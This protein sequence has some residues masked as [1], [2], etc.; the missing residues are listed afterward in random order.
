MKEVDWQKI[1][2]FYNQGHTWRELQKEFGLYSEAIKKGIREG[3][4]T[5]RSKEESQK[6]RCLKPFPK[7]SQ[8]SKLK[9]SQRRKEILAKNP[10]KHPWKSKDKFKSK[11][12]EQAK[13]F[14]KELNVHFIEEFNPEIEGRF[15]SI[16]IAMPDKMIAIEINGQQHYNSDGSLKDYYQE[17]HNLLTNNG[18]KVFEVH[19]S[20]CFKLEK[21]QEFTSLIKN[22]P[23]IKEFDYFNYVPQL[24]PKKKYTCPHCHGEKKEKVS[25]VCSTCRPLLRRKVV[26]PT[27]EELEILVQDISMTQIAKNIGVSSTTVKKWCQNYCISIPNARSLFKQK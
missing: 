20:A 16:D 3:L 25:K 8:E 15:F 10:E 12:C 17:R 18:W 21:W 11:P 19:Y 6:L 5:V 14:L 1:Q 26:R 22:E 7:H 27:K 4:L 9:M 2:E 24:K 13:S 23:N